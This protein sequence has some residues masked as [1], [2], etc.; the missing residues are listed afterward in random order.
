M[1]EALENNNDTILK[2]CDTIIKTSCFLCK[3]EN[4]CHKKHDKYINYEKCWYPISTEKLLQ[5][6]VENC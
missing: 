5:M 4:Y 2:L 1:M 6:I 3:H